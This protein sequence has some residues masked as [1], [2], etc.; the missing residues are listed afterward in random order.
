MRKTLVLALLGL[1]LP[2][3]AQQNR[4]IMFFWGDAPSQG[5]N[6]APATDTPRGNYQLGKPLTAPTPVVPS[7]PVIQP[8]PV[9]QPVPSAAV[10]A[11]APVA[12]PTPTRVQPQPQLITPMPLVET[13]NSVKALETKAPASPAMPVAP[14]QAVT[15]AATAPSKPLITSPDVAEAIPVIAA[16]VERVWEVNKGETLREVLSRWAKDAKWQDVVWDDSLPSSRYVFEGH[17]TFNGSFLEALGELFS[18]LPVDLPFY[19]DYSTVNKLVYIQPKNVKDS[20]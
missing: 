3:A 20:R 13:R 16:E 19:A 1:S 12:A 10:P 4:Q 14:A 11:V 17:G 5:R 6:V 7:A 15:P 2:V 8:T 9:A 18:V